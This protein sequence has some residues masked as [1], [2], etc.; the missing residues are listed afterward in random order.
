MKKINEGSPM[1]N[2]FDYLEEELSGKIDDYTI[3]FLQQQIKYQVY[4]YASEE[5]K[6][7][8]ESI[9]NFPLGNL[10]DN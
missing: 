5:R 4:R 2:I 1:V 8:E 6:R 10:N 9:I 7:R 3:D